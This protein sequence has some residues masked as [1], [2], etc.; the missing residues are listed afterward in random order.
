M[1]GDSEK[2]STGAGQPRST[3]GL[4][5]TPSG[6]GVYLIDPAGKEYTLQVASWT[7]SHIVARLVPLTGFATP[8]NCKIYVK[9]VAGK[10]DPKPL[11]LKPSLVTALLT[12]GDLVPNND[13]AFT[14]RGPEDVFSVMPSAPAGLVV[15]GLHGAGLFTGPTG[16]DEYFLDRKL[17][18]GWVVDSVDFMS[19]NAHLTASRIGTDC[20]YLKI[21]W[22]CDA[23]L[24]TAS[25]TFKI[26]VKGPRGTTY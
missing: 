20:P 2:A 8:Q 14:A 11:I 24:K 9:N 23:P 17:R 6:S 1:D 5:G 7:N 19:E 25:Y 3:G 4:G 21:H 26:Y 10:S 16:D 12:L 18:N 13:Y 22:W 15:H